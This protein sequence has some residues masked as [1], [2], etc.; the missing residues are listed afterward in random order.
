MNVGLIRHLKVKH[1]KPKGWI[2][3]DELFKWIKGYDEAAIDVNHFT[4][5]QSNW[6]R[7]YSSDLI[8]AVETAELMH[9][10]EIIQMKELREIKLFPLLKQKI[11]L[12]YQLWLVLLRMAWLCHHQSQLE[13]KTIVENRIRGLVD[14]LLADNGEDILIVSHGALMIYIRKELIRRGF[15]GPKFRHAKNGILYLYSKNR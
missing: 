3:E 6:D 4:R 10:G 2:T 8:R 13:T 12:P 11:R 7:V 15:T 9:D 5:K 1:V 14:N